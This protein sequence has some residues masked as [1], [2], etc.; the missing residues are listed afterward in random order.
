MALWGNLSSISSLPSPG[1]PL[2]TWGGSPEVHVGVIGPWTLPHVHGTKR[3]CGAEDEGVDRTELP[4]PTAGQSPLSFKKPPPPKRYEQN[5][6]HVFIK[7]CL[8]IFLGVCVPVAP[9]PSHSSP[10]FKITQS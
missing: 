5:C 10:P 7:I 9:R 4:V 2:A 6:V 8:L 3:E 1:M